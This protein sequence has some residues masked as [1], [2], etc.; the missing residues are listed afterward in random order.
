MRKQVEK[1]T[2]AGQTLDIDCFP[3]I[4]HRTGGFDKAR[5]RFAND[6]E[7][8][9][10]RRGISRRRNAQLVNENCTPTGWYCTLTYDQGHEAHTFAEAKRDRRNFVRAIQRRCKDAKL[11]IYVGRGKNT[12][13]IHFHMIAQDIDDA[14]IRECWKYGNVDHI[15]HLREE[16]RDAQGRSIGRDYTALANYCFDHWTEEIGGHYYFHTNNL[17]EPVVEELRECEQDYS[18]GIIPEAPVGYELISVKSTNY[19]YLHFHFARREHRD[20]MVLQL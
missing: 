8:A 3:A 7:R 5:P 10:H 15:E 2:Y 17:R 20:Q 14:T 19:G 18:T 16:C 11:F 6:E 13:R 12:R 9:E 1:R 4:T